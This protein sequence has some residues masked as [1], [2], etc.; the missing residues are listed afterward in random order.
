MHN[1]MYSQREAGYL[2]RPSLPTCI[3]T[4]SS[5]RNEV[6]R[7]PCSAQFLLLQVCA[8]AYACVAAAS[9]NEQVLL[10][11]S[12][13]DH[14]GGMALQ[15]AG[16]KR[17]RR[18]ALPGAAA[19][20]LAEAGVLRGGAQAG[21]VPCQRSPGAGEFSLSTAAGGLSAQCAG[22]LRAWPASAPRGC[23]E[24]CSGD[25]TDLRPA[26][27]SGRAAPPAAE[28]CRVCWRRRALEGA[29]PA[30]QSRSWAALHRALTALA[31][32]NSS[33][34]ARQR[35]RGPYLAGRRVRAWPCESSSPALLCGGCARAA[36]ALRPDRSA[37][38]SSSRGASQPSA[39]AAGPPSVARTQKT[40]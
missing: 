39:S 9:P 8:A 20:A 18:G 37:S 34:L 10:K 17:E 4:L 24:R 22:Y 30:E 35:A 1:T 33:A 25:S 31:H 3:V 40:M 29:A 11:V 12:H 7:A 16:A 26:A 6:A 21:R 19:A 14:I 2:S 38:C 27:R 36:W 5:W 15:A 32:D 13:A 28:R 23:A